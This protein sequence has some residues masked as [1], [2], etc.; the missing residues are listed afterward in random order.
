MQFGISPSGALDYRS[1]ALA[2]LLVGNPPDEAGIE[3]TLAGPTLTFHQQTLIALAGADLGAT[4][5]G[6]EI[7]LWQSF[8]VIPGDVLSFR[9]RRR[10]CRCYLAVAGGIDVPR[11]LGSRSTDLVA[12]IGGLEGRALRDGDALFA[13]TPAARIRDLAGSVVRPEAIPPFP[14]TG[15]WQVRVIPGPQADRFSDEGIE[16]FYSST[17]T[18][19]ASSNRTGLRLSGPPVAHR[20]G[21]DIISDGLPLGAVQVPGDGSPIVLLAD[22]N[23][24]GGYAKIGVVFTPDVWRLGQAFPGERVRFRRMT[25]DEAHA[26]LKADPPLE[27]AILFPGRGAPG[28]RRGE[29]T[30]FRL[31]IDGQPFVVSVQHP[32]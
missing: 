5:N 20:A 28:G 17:Y 3:I 11:V 12:K 18:I 23:T 30:V 2:N 26:V 27:E 8:P 10:G 9:G 7:P 16:T 1:L 19:T 22:R 13:G 21:A 32:G 15:E 6:G 4:L 31:W 25:A 29:R 14:A 24:V